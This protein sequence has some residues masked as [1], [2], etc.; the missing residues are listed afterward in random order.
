MNGRADGMV[1]G[2]MVRLSCGASCD[3]LG[4]GVNEISR[5]EFRLM[6]SGS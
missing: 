2:M 5:W 1:L 4:R 6:N 3:C